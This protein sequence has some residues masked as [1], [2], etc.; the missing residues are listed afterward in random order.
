MPTDISGKREHLVDGSGGRN[1]NSRGD[2][3]SDRRTS[4]RRDSVA[5]N[6]S[7]VSRRRHQ[8][9]SPTSDIITPP[10]NSKS[11]KR[12][13]G[14]DNDGRTHQNQSPTITTPNSS[15][16]TARYSECSPL[17]KANLRPIGKTSYIWAA[18]D[19]EGVSLCQNDMD[20][21]NH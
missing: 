21:G 17:A 10:R 1:Q 6:T 4:I 16:R 11:N 7:T 3:N 9:Q 19:H 8:N 15:T 18:A 5:V 13:R 14:E 20:G 2:D 12:S